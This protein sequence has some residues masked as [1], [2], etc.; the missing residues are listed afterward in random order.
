MGH[1]ALNDLLLFCLLDEASVLDHIGELDEVSEYWVFV[2]LRENLFTL[3]PL[4][5]LVLTVLIILQIMSEDRH[6]DFVEA[7]KGI[8]RAAVPFWSLEEVLS[9]RVQPLVR[10]LSRSSSS[11]A[12]CWRITQ[13]SIWSLGVLLLHVSV[14]CRIREIRFLTVLALEVPSLVIVLGS[15]LAD[16]P[17]RVLILIFLVRFFRA[18]DIVLALILIVVIIHLLFLLLLFA[19][20]A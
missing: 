1:G 10:I 14:K 4:I 7:A 3:F 2:H 6:V 12:T 8:D 20:T 18:L 17:R 9:S 13:L 5:F 15:S 19:I 11:P 16:L